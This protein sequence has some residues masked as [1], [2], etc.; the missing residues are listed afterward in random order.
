MAMGLDEKIM[1][2]WVSRKLATGIHA[3]PHGG[4]TELLHARF[5][6]HFVIEY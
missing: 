2:Q 3:K 6:H 1:R 4:G 5:T